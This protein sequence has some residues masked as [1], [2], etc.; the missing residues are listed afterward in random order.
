MAR[1]TVYGER[2]ATAVR[3]PVAVHDDLL[4][5]ADEREV[6]VNY[7]IVKACERYLNAEIGKRR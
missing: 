4:E 5:L 2:I 6:S 3:I 7:L 1:P